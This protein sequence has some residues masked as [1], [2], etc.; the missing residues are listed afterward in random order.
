MKAHLEELKANKDVVA[1]AY[2]QSADRDGKS[3]LAMANSYIASSKPELA[4]PLLQEIITK[5]PDTDW[6]VKAKT[7][8]DTLR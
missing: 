3:N 7:L 8:L 6:A 2:H 5:Y 1:I 4:K